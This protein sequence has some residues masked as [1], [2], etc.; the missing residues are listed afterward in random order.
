MNQH[1]LDYI[2][3]RIASAAAQYAPAHRPTAAQVADAASVLR[4]MLQA[5]QTHGV[6]F[7]HLDSVADFPRLAIQLVQSR[8][9]NR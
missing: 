7:A 1:D 3:H 5:A 6:T 4:D 9:E 8:D 2:A